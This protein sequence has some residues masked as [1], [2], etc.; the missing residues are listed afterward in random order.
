M[1]LEG[2]RDS[3][4][5]PQAPSGPP[6]TTTV[7]PA[8]PAKPL[9]AQIPVRTSTHQLPSLDY[10]CLNNPTMRTAPGWERMTPAKAQ[11]RPGWPDWHTA[12]DRK[13]EQLKHLGTYEP[14]QCP[15][16]CKPIGCKWVFHLKR[17]AT[18]AIVKYK[19]Q[20]VAQGFAQKPAS[21]MSKHPRPLCGSRHCAPSLPLDLDIHVIDVVSV[22]LNGE[23]QEEI[24][25]RQPPMC[26][27][28]QPA[29]CHLHRTLY[30]L[31][32]L[33]SEWNLKL[34]AAFVALGFTR[35]LSDQ[36]V[37]RH[38]TTNHLALVA[39]HVDDMTMLTS[40]P[41]DSDTLTDKLE[42]HFELSKLGNIHQVVGLEVDRNRAHGTLMLRQAQY[43]AHVL[44]H[45]GMAL[46]NPVNMPLDVNVHLVRH[47]GP[48]DPSAQSLYQASWVTHVRRT[49]HAP[50]HRARR[51][52]AQPV[53]EKPWPRAA[54][55]VLCYLKGAPGFGL[56]Y[57]RADTLEPFSYSNTD[58]ANGLND[59]KLILGQV[60]HLA[61]TPI[62]WASRKQHINTKSSMEAAYMAASAAASK[63]AWLR[64]LLNQAW[65]GASSSTTR[66]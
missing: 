66:A 6:N 1:P 15:P 33:G 21:N 54:K 30:G 11:A 14:A 44:E 22:Y 23:L 35:L 7:P 56:T 17:N 9:P 19:A 41:A 39:V 31:K 25:M 13:V 53:F 38:A 10:R 37:Y 58:Q 28:G 26:E 63:I 50:G 3:Q 36:C 32:Q 48:E 5:M 16:D 51:P 24:Y 40:S 42:A 45:F 2:E 34:D 43:I 52:A 57:R 55:H 18:G 60:F 64:T 62:T 49:W 47:D 65:H 8:A 29:T 20:L 12:V 61:G 46:V 4:D 59:R 27:N